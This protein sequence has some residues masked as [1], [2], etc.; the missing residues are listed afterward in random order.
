MASLS[1][2]KSD[3]HPK[4]QAEAAFASF[5]ISIVSSKKIVSFKKISHCPECKKL[6]LP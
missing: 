5:N 1:A 6:I 3:N 2:K 4:E